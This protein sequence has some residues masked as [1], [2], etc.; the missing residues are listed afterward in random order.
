MSHHFPV[1]LN[2]GVITHVVLPIRT[3]EKLAGEPAAALQPIF[4]DDVR[5]AV[6][7]LN[8]PET[9]WHDAN[10]LLQRLI[11]EGIEQARRQRGITQAQLGAA[12]GLSQPQISRIERNPEGAPLGI[13]RRIAQMLAA[14]PVVPRS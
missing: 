10:A 12:V 11:H 9:Q 1:L 13:L 7:I 6:A 14:A 8:D 3:Y 2:D 4:A 5:A